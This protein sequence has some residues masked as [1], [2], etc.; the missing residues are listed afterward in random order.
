MKKIVFLIFLSTLVNISVAQKAAQIKNTGCIFLIDIT[1]NELFGL[2]KE[3]IAKNLQTFFRATGL[4]T[5]NELESFTLSVAPINSTG[6]L[7][8]SSKSISI[9]KKGLSYKEIEQLRNPKPL[10]ALLK[11]QLAIYDS[12]KAFHN[13]KSYIIDVILKTIAQSNESSERNVIVVFSDLLEYS[14]VSNFYKKIPQSSEIEQ[15]IKNIDPILLNQAKKKIESSS[16][17][18]VVIVFKQKK[19]ALTG[20]ALKQFWSGFLTKLGISKVV[21]LDNL[22][23]NPQL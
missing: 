10:I 9:T 15:A 23:Q 17:I 14:P 1:D 6:E 18:E 13:D 21:F 12:I 3:D 20:N 2:I 11:K 5:I 8:L 7:H 16:D 19:G 4:G 22:T